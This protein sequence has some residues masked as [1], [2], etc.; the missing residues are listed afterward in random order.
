MAKPTFRFDSTGYGDAHSAGY[1][2][3]ID[4]RDPGLDSN[5]A[6]HVRVSRWNTRTASASLRATHRWADALVKAE[7]MADG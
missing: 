6:F 2:R 5:Y 1:G 4:P 7:A 3:T